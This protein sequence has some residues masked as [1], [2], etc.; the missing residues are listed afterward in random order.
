[1]Q[2]ETTPDS[3]TM[4]HITAGDCIRWAYGLQ[5]YEIVGPTWIDPPTDFYY[6]IVAKAAGPA[7]DDQ[8]K[9]MLRTLLADR[10]KLTVHREKRGLP[11]YLLTVARNGHKLHPADRSETSRNEPGGGP[12][13]MRFVNVSMPRFAEMLDSPWNSR[14]VLDRTG[15]EGGFDFAWDLAPYLIDPGTGK[16]I[17]D[18]RGAVDME[19]AIVRGLADQLGLRLEPTKAPIDVLVID[20]LEKMPTEN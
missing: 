3:L 19:D 11:V 7:R 15:L 10:F 1:M 5:P 6:D 9:L 16:P 12:Y 17:L 4:R 20:H 14:P 8:L 18:A 2:R 13:Q